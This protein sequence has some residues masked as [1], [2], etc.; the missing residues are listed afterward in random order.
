MILRY[1]NVAGASDDAS[2]GDSKKPSRHLVQNAV[3]GALG[4]EPF[5]LT[6]PQVDTPDKTT[7]RDYV[8]VVDLNE[9]HIKAVEHLFSGGTSDILN[10]GTGT[11]D[12]VLSI[13]KKVEEITGKTIK[14]ESGPPREGEYATIYADISKAQKILQWSPTRTIHDSV[15][16]LVSWYSKHPNGWTNN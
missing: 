11:G 8:N 3:R 16:S 1:F 7:I 6:S 5:Y 13:V 14:I 2:I 15:T 10:L 9:A 4:I 12:S